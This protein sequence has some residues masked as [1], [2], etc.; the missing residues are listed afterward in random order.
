[1]SG[2]TFRELPY[3]LHQIEKPTGERSEFMS[4]D[5]FLILFLILLAFMTLFPLLFRK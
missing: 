2:L 5:A 4:S 3:T 1:M